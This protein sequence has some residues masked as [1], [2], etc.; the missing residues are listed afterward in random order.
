MIWIG[1]VRAQGE[2][3]DHVPKSDF[4]Q[5]ENL[6][7]SQSKTGRPPGSI[8]VLIPFFLVVGSFEIL[9][10]TSIPETTSGPN[11]PSE[12]PEGFRNRQY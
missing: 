12:E 4:S 6:E 2:T 7:L 1:T 8:L 10:A 11:I 3:I 9:S 5:H